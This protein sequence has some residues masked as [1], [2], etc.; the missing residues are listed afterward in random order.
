M[1]RKSLSI[2]LP[3]CAGA[4]SRLVRSI[5]SLTFI[6]NPNELN[7][8]NRSVQ[9]G[10]FVEKPPQIDGNKLRKENW[11]LGGNS[12]KYESVN[13]TSFVSPRKG[14]DAETLKEQIKGIKDRVKGVNVSY[15]AGS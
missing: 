4:I 2:L 15:K 7:F 5:N 1:T 3:T 14:E 13:Q 10:G 12:F 9:R 11:T 8:R 6:G